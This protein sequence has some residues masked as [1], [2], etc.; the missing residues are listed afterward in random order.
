MD[1]EA[2][3]QRYFQLRDQ[4]RS[5]QEARSIVDREFGGRGAVQEFAR[6]AGLGLT[7][8]GTSLA[9]GVGWLGAKA[10]P[11]EALDRPFEA[12]ESGAEESKKDPRSSL[13]LAEPPV[14]LGA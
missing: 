12:L 5:A 10:L 4:G 1:E 7:E 2:K 3:K 6:G 13:I 11:G 8:A 9:K 14:L